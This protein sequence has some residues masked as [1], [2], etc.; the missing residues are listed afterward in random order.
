MESTFKILKWI[1]IVC[2]PQKI[3][4]VQY[5]HILLHVYEIQF[6]KDKPISLFLYLIPLFTSST[7][8]SGL[9]TLFK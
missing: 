7:C 4:I 5:I 9:A 8:I 2:L 3:N 6:I 1:H